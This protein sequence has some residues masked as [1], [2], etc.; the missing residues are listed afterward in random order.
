MNCGT[1]RPGEGVALEPQ[2]EPHGEPSMAPRVLAWTIRGAAQ[3]R[4]DT[5]DTSMDYLERS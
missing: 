2:R 1:L 5:P 3:T 4:A